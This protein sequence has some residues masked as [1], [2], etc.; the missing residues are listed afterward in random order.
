MAVAAR[1]L[2]AVVAFPRFTF[3]K[4]GADVSASVVVLEKTGSS[5]GPCGDSERYPFHAGLLES[6][7]WSVGDKGGNAFTNATQRPE[8]TIGR[9]Q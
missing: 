1:K 9:R 5:A 2:V 4:S 7:G 8:P 3:K 6:V